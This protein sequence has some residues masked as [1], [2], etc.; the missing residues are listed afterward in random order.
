MIWV[1]RIHMYLGLVLFPW[2]V[3]F[4]VT[5]ILFNHPGIGEAVVARPI[6]PQALRE[7][8]GIEPIEPSRLAREAVERLR[9]EG[10]AFRLDEGFESRFHGAAAFATEGPGVKHLVLLNLA[11]G[12]G[13]LLTR[14]DHTPPVAPFR[15]VLDVPAHRMPSVEARL[16]PLMPKLGVADAAHPPRAVIAPSVW[17]RLIDG[18]GRTWNATYDLGSGLLDGRLAS[19]SPD[20][21]LHDLLG[22]MHKTHHFPPVL[23]PTTFWAAFADLTGATL[24]LWA[25]T[26]ILMWVQIK[27]SRAL[28]VVA[29]SVGL[30][31]AACTMFA[32]HQE[33]RFGNVRPNEP[34]GS[35][36]SADR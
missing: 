30:L 1:R 2:V 5:G 27:K 35:P 22:E 16:E 36:V 21:S 9:A 29:V 17:F 4:G 19:A 20:L 32:T 24:I 14:P 11:G 3:F 23:G 28:G 10:H 15:G 12:R 7:L 34:G 18:E 26:G 33:L 8:T 25:V 6:P 13:V 31:V